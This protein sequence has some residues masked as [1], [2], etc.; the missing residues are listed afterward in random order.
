M[1]LASSHVLDLCVELAGIDDVE[2]L[3]TQIVH[4][5]AQILGAKF[6]ALMGLNETQEACVPLATWPIGHRLP[7][8]NLATSERADH[9]II[10]A[11]NL[12]RLIEEAAQGEQSMAALR[13]ILDG[14]QDDTRLVIVPARFASGS[15]ADLVF[16]AFVAKGGAA[17]GPTELAEKFARFSARQSHVLRQLHQSLAAAD[18]LARSVQSAD[19]SRDFYQQALPAALSATLVGQSPQMQDLR[20]L[21][22]SL[23]PGSGTVLIE[24]ETGTGKQLAALELHRL[25]ERRNGPFVRVRASELVK[26]DKHL[27]GHSDDEAGIVVIRAGL[28]ESAHRGTLF[29]DEVSDLPLSLQAKILRAHEQRSFL[30]A[31]STQALTSD[32]RLIAATQRP[33]NSL[34]ARQRLHDRLFDRQFATRVQLLPLRERKDDIIELSQYFLQRDAQLRGRSANVLSPTAERALLGCAYPGNVRQLQTLITDAIHFTGQGQTIDEKH[35][36]CLL[37]GGPD[38]EPGNWPGLRQACDIY[39]RDLIRRSLL[40]KGGDRSRTARELRVPLRT[41]ADKLKKY[42]LERYGNEIEDYGIARRSYSDPATG[43]VRQGLSRR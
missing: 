39:E 33:I 14:E 31:G 6:V 24:G 15:F 37:E 13:G 19:R 18:V 16:F 20:S 21:I 26:P 40:S 3:R 23:A 28:L 11:L 4:C 42:G 41:L 34:I 25:S 32:F 8:F 38:G 36:R 17:R 7:A 2:R 10:W 5:M 43:T 9:P 12:P 29:I 22:S 30:P 1:T 27:F 35:V